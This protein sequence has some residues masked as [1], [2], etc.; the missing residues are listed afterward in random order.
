MGPEVGGRLVI[1]YRRLFSSGKKRN[2]DMELPDELLL[3]LD[4]PIP[5]RELQV[6]QLHL[7]L[8]STHYHPQTLVIHGVEATA[9]TLTIR[10]VLKAI[11][12]PS[13]IVRCRECITTRHLLER[14][15]TSTNEAL[16][17]KGG[18][19]QPPEIDGRCESISAFV[20]QLEHLL[21]GKGRF[22][23]VFDGIDRQREAAPTLLPAL[24][25][26]GEIKMPNLAVVLVIR[27][28]R[29]HLLHRTG[30]PYLHFPPYTRDETL[31][32][33]STSPMPL[34]MPEKSHCTYN[35][36]DTAWL[37]QRFL[38][39]AWESLG[40][41]AARDIISFRRVCEK[42]WPPFIQPVLEGLYGPKEFSK[43]LVKNRALLQSESA[44]ADNIVTPTHTILKC[45]PTTCESPLFLLANLQEPRLN[46]PLASHTL[47]YIPSHLLIAAYLA[48]H[49]PPK[50]DIT[51]FSKAS[52]S[53]RRKRRGGTALTPHRA[54]KHR[55]I[56]H[57]VLGP[58]AF[59]LERLFAIF[60]A[61]VEG[62][63][64]A[65]GADVMCQFATLVGL[66]LVVRAGAGSGG[67]GAGDVLE[68]GG[69]WRVN[70][71]Y[72]FAREV[73]RGVRFDVDS[74]IME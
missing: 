73:A 36:E 55:K 6:Q 10:A 9:K 16:K 62:V 5:C 47:P 34:I 21:K 46:R 66:R 22:I 69:K 3:S 64:K 37:W 63:M 43:L 68:G 18:G 59:V 19:E 44:M 30:L 35:D 13:A 65:G 1:C 40:Q 17:Q 42:L 25:R 72:E 2:P 74:Y 11:T 54:Y 38:A 8:G 23:L 4:D 24:A 45:K 33:L 57:R 39:A 14:A 50:N 61:I 20:V 48:S 49:N 12:I 56:S 70:V 26:L 27:T 28:P 41:G 53:K 32:I 71:G 15:I 29:A 67:G 31:S 58:Q 60:H 52:L 7:L 51:L